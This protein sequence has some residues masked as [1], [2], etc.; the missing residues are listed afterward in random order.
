MKRDPLIIGVT[1]VLVIAFTLSLLNIYVFPDIFFNID[2]ERYAINEFQEGLLI[3]TEEISFDSDIF[4][5]IN[6]SEITINNPENAL[7]DLSIMIALAQDKQSAAFDNIEGL[8]PRRIKLQYNGT[9][10]GFNNESQIY[11]EWIN[12][13]FDGNQPYSYLAF[14]NPA[15]NYEVFTNFTLE[16]VELF[17]IND[18]LDALD[19]LMSTPSIMPD[20]VIYQTVEYSESR[21]M[22]NE[23]ST[24]F[25][26]MIFIDT[27]GEILFF[28]TNEGQWTKPL[29]Y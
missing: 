29:L 23:Y 7:I 12:S 18:I 16:D 15:L 25:K 26:R 4:A 20:Y 19:D 28:L 8:M 5:G 24:Q 2:V 6:F 9:I 13:N 10:V 27:F 22:F 1:S 17:L 14:K 11:E 21:G 3:E